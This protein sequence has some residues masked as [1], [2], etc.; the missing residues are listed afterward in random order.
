MPLPPSFLK[1]ITATHEYTSRVIDK[2]SFLEGA[3]DNLRE[4]IDG[5]VGAPWV[6][7]EVI[8]VTEEH[9]ECTTTE[10]KAREG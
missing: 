9:M 2:E 1:G 5:G 8:L 6:L 10:H 7:V 4:V 3:M